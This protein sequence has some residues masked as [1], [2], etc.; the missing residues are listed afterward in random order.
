MTQ[1]TFLGLAIW[2]LEL[3]CDLV[4]GPALR[5]IG[6]SRELKE[7]SWHLTTI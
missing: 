1:K 6:S 4:L 5:G 3:I 2:S 7:F